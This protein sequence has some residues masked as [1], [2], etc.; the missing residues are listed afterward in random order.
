MIQT[1][2]SL[3]KS[4]DSLSHLIKNILNNRY[5]PLCLKNRTDLAAWGSDVFEAQPVNEH[6]ASLV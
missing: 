4:R 6:S 2:N 3:I 1:F 5:H